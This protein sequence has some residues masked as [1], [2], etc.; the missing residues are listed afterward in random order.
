MI[1]KLTY[2]Y[3][4]GLLPVVAQGDFSEPIDQGPESGFQTSIIRNYCQALHD[5]L[6]KLIDY[7]NF[8]GNQQ[9]GKPRK[10]ATMFAAPLALARCYWPPRRGQHQD[11]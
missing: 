7:R 10:L 3:E 11:R 2:L 5:W 4:N 8:P 6:N 1:L 9:K